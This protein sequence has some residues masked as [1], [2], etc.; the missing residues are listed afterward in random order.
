[1]S[2][3]QNATFTVTAPH[4]PVSHPITVHYSISGTAQNGSDYTL[5]GTFGQVTIQT[6]QSSAT[7]ILHAVVDH[8]NENSETAIMTLTS[9]TGYTVPSNFKKATVTIPTNHT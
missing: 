8:H 9:G 1:V 7:V 6:G 2:E 3:G 5:S 4:G